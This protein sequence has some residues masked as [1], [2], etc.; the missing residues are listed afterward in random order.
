[1]IP[2]CRRRVPTLQ[3][4]Q[5]RQRMR[6]VVP[7][8]AAMQCIVVNACGIEHGC[9]RTGSGGRICRRAGEPPTWYASTRPVVVHF[10][11]LH[12]PSLPLPLPLSCRPAF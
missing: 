5:E 4:W 3:Q 10:T 12:C 11:L 1:M 2:V 8:A 9:W 7:V 6:R